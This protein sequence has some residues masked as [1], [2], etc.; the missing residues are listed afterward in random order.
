MTD[1]TPRKYD[2]EF[3]RPHPGPIQTR[4][5]YNHD[6]GK[7]TR[8]VIQLEYHHGGDWHEVVRYDHD[9][10]GSNEATHDVTEEG[11]HMDIYRDGTVEATEYV[12]P[13][14]EA[15]VAMDR[16]ED[17]LSKNLERFVTRYEQWHGISNQ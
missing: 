14:I 6:R 2:R 1:D 8:F 17:H 15:A 3:R 16:A 9:A 4:V 11:I 5:G 7:V 10:V 13:P 12:S